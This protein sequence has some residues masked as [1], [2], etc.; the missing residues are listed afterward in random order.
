MKPGAGS[1]NEGSSLQ[2]SAGAPALV[3]L[4]DRVIGILATVLRARIAG[5]RRQQPRGRVHPVKP[6]SGFQ[7]F[8]LRISKRR[9][10][11]FA[12]GLAMLEFRRGPGVAKQF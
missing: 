9:K 12:K 11:L 3:R 2:G 5:L 10:H 6:M 8:V 1:A 7:M 4:K